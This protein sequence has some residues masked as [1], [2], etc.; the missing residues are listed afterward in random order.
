MIGAMLCWIIMN[1]SSLGTSPGKLFT[2]IWL[3]M[4]LIFNL[5]L[6]FVSLYTVL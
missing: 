6:G 2:L 5:I 1:W 4:L 3:I